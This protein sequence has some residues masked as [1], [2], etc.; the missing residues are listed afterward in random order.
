M[1]DL[2]DSIVGVTNFCTA[3][4]KAIRQKARIGGT[5]NP[6]VRRIVALRPDLV[7]VNTDENRLTTAQELETLGLRILVTRTDSLDEVEAT[8]TAWR[9][10][11][12]TSVSSHRAGAHQSGAGT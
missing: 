10:D 1:L 9:S 2:E 4:A 8:W 5:K 3:P 6:D 12:K 7:I 11:W